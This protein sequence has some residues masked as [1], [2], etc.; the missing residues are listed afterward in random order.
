MSKKTNSNSKSLNK[1]KTLNKDERQY[2]HTC[3][4]FVFELAGHEK[5][6]IL[7][8]IDDSMLKKPIST[9]LEPVTKNAANAVSF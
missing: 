4:Q 9:I 6:P 2:C 5:H 7:S 8:D 3:S 1:V